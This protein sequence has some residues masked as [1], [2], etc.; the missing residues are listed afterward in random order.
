MPIPDFL[1]V[2][3]F[4]ITLVFIRPFEVLCGILWVVGNVIII[5]LCMALFIIFIKY[6]K[7]IFFILYL[8]VLV[9]PSNTFSLLKCIS[10]VIIILLYRGIQMW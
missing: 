3:F 2:E 5:A 1:R 7:D 6:F 8:N 10:F 4:F 9:L